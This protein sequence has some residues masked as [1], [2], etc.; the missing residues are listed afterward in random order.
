MASIGRNDPCPCGS[1]KKYKKCCMMKDKARQHQEAALHAHQGGVEKAITW[2]SR[3]YGDEIDAWMA[4]VWFAGVDAEAVNNL[5]RAQ[6]EMMEINAME[7]MLAEGSWVRESGEKIVF[8]DKVL[9]RGGPLMGAEQRQYLQALQQAPL[10]LWEVSDVSPGVGLAL[11]DCLDEIEA[12]EVREKSASM[13]LKQWDVIGARPVQ[14]PAGHWE[15]SG[16][17][18]HIP[19]NHV[20]AVKQRIKH[21]AE[22][23]MKG[24][25]QTAISRVITSEWLHLLLEPEPFIP[26][27]MDA[28]TGEP[29]LMITEHYRVQDW[30]ALANRLSAIPD[31][32]GDRKQ[33]WTRFQMLDKDM[34]R[35]LVA[36]N[37]GKQKNRIELFTKSRQGADEQQA[38]FEEIAGD[39]VQHLTREIGD[40]MSLLAHH[41]EKKAAP[42]PEIPDNVQKQLVHDYKRRHYAGWADEPL[43]ALN[44]QTAR[45][46]VKTQDGRKTVAALLK[47]FENAE[48]REVHPFDFDF[49]W[50]ELGLG[51]Q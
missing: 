51:R 38:W 1:G 47:D 45:E 42:A 41:D 23:A 11:T 24:E 28:A 7:L 25:E 30:E 35:S 49:L 36:I 39:A 40:L 9:E 29:M 46:A 37:L 48:A 50:K 27:I 14:T 17:I 3:R 44:G 20:D 22:M 4:G 5:S 10:R 18:Y 43:P 33:G 19:R 34:R 13:Q 26:Q 21:E 32:E 2:L 31:V 6:L 12:R 8:M 16:G 15:L